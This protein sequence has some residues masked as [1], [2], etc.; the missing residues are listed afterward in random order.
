[1][2]DTLKFCVTDQI[3]KQIQVFVHQSKFNGCQDCLRHHWLFVMDLSCLKSTHQADCRSWPHL[4]PLQLQSPCL[5][6][7]SVAECIL[8]SPFPLWSQDLL[9]QPPFPPLIPVSQS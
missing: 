5:I 8:W 3:Y 4:L 6:P 1:M 2:A 7:R 9:L